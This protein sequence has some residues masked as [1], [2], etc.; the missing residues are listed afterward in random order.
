SSP[1]SPRRP[2]TPRL[3][4]SPSSF[5]VD[6]NAP[7]TAPPNS[8]AIITSVPSLLGEIDVFFLGLLGGVVGTVPQSDE[9]KE[10]GH[11][12][13]ANVAQGK[14][15]ILVPFSPLRLASLLSTDLLAQ[16]LKIEAN[17]VLPEDSR[18]HV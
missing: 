18:W 5:S 13:G 15:A 9:L 14:A 16:E 4:P 10:P 2:P 3:L 11:P 7:T 1:K 6:N 17:A 12:S 8:H